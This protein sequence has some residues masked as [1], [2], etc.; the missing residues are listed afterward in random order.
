[1]VSFSGTVTAP[2]AKWDVAGTNQAMT[3]IGLQNNAYLY[4]LVAPTSGNKILTVSWTTQ[5]V[6]AILNCTSFTGALQTGGTTTFPNKVSSG[7]AGQPTQTITSATGDMVVAMATCATV[8]FTSP[9]QTSL[10]A[11]NGTSVYSSGQYAAGAA[12]VTCS[13]T[14]TGTYMESIG[15]DIAAVVTVH[16]ISNAGGNANATTAWVDGTVPIAG[17]SIIASATS[18]TLTINVAFPV[19]GTLASVDFTSYTGLLVMSNT[20][21]VAG[22]VTLASGMTVQGASDL[23]CS[24]TATLT[25][26]IGGS[27]HF[28]GGLQLKGT[29]QTYTMSGSWVID[30]TLTLSEIGRAHV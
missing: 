12:T 8:G 23:I 28:T 22:P 17:D 7:G 6:T 18:G 13:W 19:S 26:S 30:G 14:G 15:C 4:G 24:A 16:T 29:S 1:M 11:K 9:N 27:R 25:F 2:T 20:L 3:L 10:Y 5:S 21:S